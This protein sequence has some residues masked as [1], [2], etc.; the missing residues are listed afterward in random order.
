M[1]SIINNINTPLSGITAKVSKLINVAKSKPPK[2][3]DII[4]I[5]DNMITASSGKTIK[6]IV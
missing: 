2:L 4:P 3:G 6:R 5:I 1:L